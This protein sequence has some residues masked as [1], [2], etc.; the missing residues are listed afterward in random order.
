MTTPFT[1][2]KLSGLE[3]TWR[4]D[5]FGDV[6]YPDMQ[7]RSSQPSV[8]VQFSC[9]SGVS[10]HEHRQVWLPIGLL[11]MLKVGDLWE[12][13][14]PTGKNTAPEKGVLDNLLINHDTGV[15]LGRSFNTEQA[16]SQ[17]HIVHFCYFYS[18]P[19]RSLWKQDRYPHGCFTPVKKKCC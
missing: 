16:F 3:G 10:I 5:W 1:I 19:V 7:A 13:G 4:V 2:E 17:I 9:H 14:S 12:K 8:A 6:A 15:V 18:Q 11:P